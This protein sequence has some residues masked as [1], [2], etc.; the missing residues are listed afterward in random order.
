MT[1][2]SGSIP[3][4]A[5]W[6]FAVSDEFY[7]DRKVGQYRSRSNDAIL[8]REAVFDLTRANISVQS[9]TLIELADQLADGTLSL[10]KFQFQAGDLLRRIHTQSAILGRGG[11]DKM[12]PKDWL[13]V[14]R[15]LVKQYY[16][17]RDPETGKRFGLKHLATEIKKGLVSLPQLRNAMRQYA[18]SGKVSY[19]QA[20]IATAKEQGTPYAIREL[21][22]VEHC[23]DCPRLAALPPLP[24]DQITKP[25]Q[26]CACRTNCKCRLRPLTLEQAIARGMK[27]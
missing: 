19:W 27:R 5:L 2:I 10:R 1:E 11:I 3:Q 15:E 14:G 13:Q 9:E 26:G 18:D 25:T 24:L 20:A 7:F 17:G 21:G 23:D 4:M 22:D 12:K 16:A 6:Q 8:P